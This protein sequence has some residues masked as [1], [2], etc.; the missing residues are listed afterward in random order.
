VLRLSNAS[1]AAGAGGT[2][3]VGEAVVH[4]VAD[5]PVLEPVAERA[6]GLD[7]SLS[8][9]TVASSSSSPSWRSSSS[10]TDTPEAPPEHRRVRQ[11]ALRQRI[12]R[13]DLGGQRA[14]QRRGTASSEPSSCAAVMSSPTNSGLPLA[15]V[16]TRS[17]SCGRNGAASVALMA[18]ARTTSSGSGSIGRLTQRGD[19]A[20]RLVAAQ[21]DQQPRMRLGGGCDR[22]SRNADASSAH[23]MSSATKTSGRRGRHD[24][25]QHD[26][27]GPVGTELRLIETFHGGGNASCRAS[28]RRGRNGSR[29]GTARATVRAADLPSLRVAVPDVRTA[30]ERI[31][32]D[33]VAVAGAVGLGVHVDERGCVRAQR[34]AHQS[35]LAETGSTDQRHDT[36]PVPRQPRCDRRMGQLGVATEEREVVVGRLLRGPVPRRPGT[37]PAAAPCP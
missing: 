4:D 1:P 16:T 9:A 7:E 33:P 5:Q 6:V 31:A 13:I 25:F 18:S 20:T 22:P 12:E 28:P 10:T 23:C 34:L 3:A 19:E 14:L 29:C 17:T 21:R 30:P 32:H 2:R 37:P 26:V 27:G 8:W 11:H 36:P 35:R 24:Q 15:R